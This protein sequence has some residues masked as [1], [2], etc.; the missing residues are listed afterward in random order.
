MEAER[1]TRHIPSTLPRPRL[2]I[3]PQFA[4]RKIFNKNFLFASNS[5][6][7]AKKAPV[8]M[9]K[10]SASQLSAKGS[11]SASCLPIGRCVCE[12]ETNPHRT[13]GG[14]TGGPRPPRAMTVDAPHAAE[15]PSS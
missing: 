4:Q 5:F 13:C 3:N 11:A 10:Q 12:I 14:N 9:C 1:G 6:I 15:P 7:Q 2:K 8:Q